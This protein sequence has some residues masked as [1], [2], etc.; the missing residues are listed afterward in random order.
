VRIALLVSAILASTCVGQ[1]QEDRLYLAR[2]AM[3][4]YN[5]PEVRA[6]LEGKSGTVLTVADKSRLLSVL[7]GKGQHSAD[8]KKWRAIADLLLQHGAQIDN[9][10][11]DRGVTALANASLNWSDQFVAYLLSKGADPNAGE[12]RDP[13]SVPLPAA[14][15]TQD[16]NQR[17]P[18]FKGGKSHETGETAAQM[19]GRFRR[20]VALLLAAGADPMRPGYQGMIP[21]QRACYWGETEIVRHMLR[22]GA[23][24][25]AEGPPGPTV[26]GACGYTALHCAVLRDSADNAATVRLLLASGADRNAKDDLGRTPLQ[27]A[28]HKGNKLVA[29]ALGG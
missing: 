12:L 8:M 14:L 3:A 29:K 23:R 6:H 24:P 15:L 21:F 16:A 17:I 22:K 10:G 11:T 28:R 19:L 1:A 18:R 4:A 26:Y 27:L 25:N 7:A 2:R 20:T 13:T 9:P 5:L